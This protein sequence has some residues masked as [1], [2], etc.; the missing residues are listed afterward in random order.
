MAR[1]PSKKSSPRA[2]RKSI[3]P[4]A[5]KP[6]PSRGTNVPARRVVSIDALRGFDMFWIM[7][8]DA[9]FPA[10]F[11]LIGTPFFL[12]LSRQLEH[13][14]WNGFTFY[15][16]IFPLFLFI[17]GCSMPFALGRRLEKGEPKKSIY[18]HIIKRTVT[19]L[20]LGLIYNGLL[21]FQFH[22]MRYAGVLQR[23][24][25]CYFFASVIFIYSKPRTQAILS[26][27]ILL[28]YWAI[29]KLIPVPGF[30][31]GVLTPEGNLAAFVDQRLLPGRFCCYT[32]GDNEG[33]ISNLPAVV[34]ALLGA[35]S[36]A[37]LKSGTGGIR[38]VLGLAAAGIASLGIAQLWN[39]FFPINKLFWS[40][41][42][43]LAA[44]GWSMLLLALFYWIID[45]RGW[46]VWAFPFVVIGLNPITIYV[47]QG[48]FDFGIIANIFVHGFIRHTGAFEQPLWLLCILAVK[49]L[50]L[51]F[52]Y[53]QKIFLKA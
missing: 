1:I 37:W 30:G 36:G 12:S 33:I 25:I 7:G 3:P 8:G 45:V 48:L 18:I 23:I 19:L 34:T 47:V 5:V 43:V 9:F 50:F 53:R 22:E 28:A 10:L 41:S 29:M 52:L 24:T 17:V 32:F 40:S 31:A 15:D 14:S 46:R 49:W 16:L 51:Y 44:G 20:F 2:V 11:A 21:N 38:K 4:A 39:P 35:L 13:S 27:V 42:Y 26:A 6:A